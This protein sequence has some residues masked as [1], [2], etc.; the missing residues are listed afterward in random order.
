[1]L[2]TAN[3]NKVLIKSKKLQLNQLIVIFLFFPK[4][5]PI[6][7]HTD[8]MCISVEQEYD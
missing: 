7:S 6:F 1:M 3:D 4:K 8:R 2:P 5:N